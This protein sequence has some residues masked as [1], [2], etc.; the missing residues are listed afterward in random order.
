MAEDLVNHW[1]IFDGSPSTRLRTGDDLQAAAAVGA[2]L[3]VKVEDPKLFARPNTD[4]RVKMDFEPTY[5]T[6]QEQFLD[7]VRHFLEEHVPQQLRHRR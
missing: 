1:R 7:M 6:E 5:T 4:V 2:V 3:D